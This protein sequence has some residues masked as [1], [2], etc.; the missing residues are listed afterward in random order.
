ME[1]NKDKTTVIDLWEVNVTGRR[2][3]GHAPG[4]LTTPEEE[5]ARTFFEARLKDL[6]TGQKVYLTHR[7]VTT[8]WFVIESS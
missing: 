6:G 8:Q 1:T 3:N 5:K 7:E 2:S 4:F